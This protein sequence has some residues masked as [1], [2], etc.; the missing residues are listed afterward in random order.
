VID[1]VRGTVTQ[2]A[3]LLVRLDGMTEAA[4]TAQVGVW[5]PT[6]GMRVVVA[7]NARTRARLYALGPVTAP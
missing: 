1:M 5:T 7:V 2:V 4:R 3:P 6:V